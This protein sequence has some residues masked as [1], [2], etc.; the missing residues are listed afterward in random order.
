VTD[1]IPKPD[2]S[3]TLAVRFLEEGR[4]E[5]PD[6]AGWLGD[7]LSQAR[8]SLDLAFYDVHLSPEPANILR[9]ALEARTRDGVR[10]RL[11]YDAG[12]KP[13]GPSGVVDTGAEPVAQP[14]H[15]RVDELGLEPEAIRA[16]TGRQALMHHKYIVRDGEAVWTGSL[17]L[18]ND[19]MSRMENTILTLQSDAIAKLYT[20][21]FNQLWE[22]ETI[23]GSG[24][25]STKP[26]PL[27]Y[28]GEDASVDVD[29]SPGQGQQINDLVAKRIANAKQRIIF[30]TML[31]T[32]SRLLNA[33]TKQ[34]DRGEVEISGVYDATQMYGVLQQWRE[35]PDLAWKVEAVERI[36]SEGKLAGKRSAPY[37][38]GAVH[39]FLHNKS[40]V[41]DDTVLTGSHNFSHS[42][43][44]NAENLLAIRSPQLAADVATFAAKLAKRYR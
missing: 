44:S 6:V 24:D 40:I 34:L 7:F 33:L 36:I 1:R 12:D 17:N 35:I 3:D 5:A 30:A 19:S 32:S 13:Q 22:S 14:D 31:F 29:F 18:S 2:A 4:Q 11:V 23:E 41:L 9:Q 28:A 20:R 27:R 42:A 8:E 39:N 25:F 10:V 43:R 38:P 26:V 16:I 15:E 37:R 21:D